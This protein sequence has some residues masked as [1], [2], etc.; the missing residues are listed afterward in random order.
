MKHLH[1]SLEVRGMGHDIDVTS[2]GVTTHYNIAEP[3]PLIRAIFSAM[4]GALPDISP[5]QVDALI[6]SHPLSA[7]PMHGHLSLDVD[8]LIETPE[9]AGSRPV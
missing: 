7:A 6:G 4:A 2:N 3:G 9:E 8:M 5:A 1:G